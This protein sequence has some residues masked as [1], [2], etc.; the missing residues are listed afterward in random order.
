MRLDL[1]TK[2]KSDTSVSAKNF[3]FNS[4][5]HTFAQKKIFVFFPETSHF[6]SSFLI[7]QDTDRSLNYPRGNSDIQ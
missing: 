4:E 1:T 6:H 7:N 2:Q 3:I 5:T